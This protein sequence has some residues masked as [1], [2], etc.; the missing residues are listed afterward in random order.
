MSAPRPFMH[1][2]CWIDPLEGVDQTK[3]KHGEKIETMVTHG[4][5]GWRCTEIVYFLRP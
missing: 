3:T 1:I 4:C 5:L 2:F